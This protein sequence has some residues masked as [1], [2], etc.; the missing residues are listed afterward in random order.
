MDRKRNILEAKSKQSFKETFGLVLD[1]EKYAGILAIATL[2]LVN[3][4]KD[5]VGSPPTI[6]TT[7]ILCFMNVFLI[8][9]LQSYAVRLPCSS[10]FYQAT[11]SSRYSAIANIHHI[12][13]P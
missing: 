9:L 13:R 7:K 10:F 3:E 2:S 4:V 8:I 1:G 6:V 5:I 11:N 12:Y